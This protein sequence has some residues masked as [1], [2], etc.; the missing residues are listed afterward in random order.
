MQKIFTIRLHWFFLLCFQVLTFHT[1]GAIPQPE[2]VVILILE[3]HSYSQ[4]VGSSA[5]PYINSII[6]DPK[7]ALFT[8]S[9]GLNHPSQPNYIQLFSGSNQG[10]TNNQIPPG[11]PF[12]SPNLGAA[13]LNA[14]KTFAGY[15]E[16]LP[17]VGS[18][19]ET[20][21]P[22]ARKH[23]PWT[24][25]QGSSI[26]G[27]PDTCSRPF[28]D[29]PTD[30]NLLPNVS[31]VIPNLDNQM[32]DGSDPARITRGDTWVHDNLDNYIQWCKTNNSVFI[33]TFDEDDGFS[34]QHILTLFTGQK[35]VHGSYPNPFNHFNVLRTLEEMFN[36]PYAGASATATPIDYCW[37]MCTHSSTINPPG[38][39]YFCSGDS[40]TLSA[41]PSASYL[42]STGETTQTINV[43]SSGIYSVRTDDGLG[44]VATS[45]DVSIT[46][47]GFP[48]AVYVLNESM[49]TVAGAT[50]IA[51]YEANNGFDNDNLT[52]TGSGDIRS[53]L[54]SANYS[55]ASGGANVFLTNTI[56]KNF[57]ISNINTSGLNG[58]ELSFGIFK[59]TTASTASDL[60]VQVSSDG[61]NYTTLS[62]P[63]LPTGTGTAVWHYRTVTG[64]IPSA[65]NLRIQF[66]Q[67]GNT[68]QYRIDDISL[69]YATSS[70]VIS[71][72]G[73]TT[74]CQ[75]GSVH[76]SSTPANSYYW[77]TGET[78][79]SITA[80]TSGN[81]YVIGSISTGCLESSNNIVVESNP[82]VSPTVNISSNIGNTFCA[83]D[84]VIFSAIPSF[85]G[86]APT[87]LWFVNG[88]S[89]GVTTSNYFNNSFLDGDVVTCVMTSN[90]ACASVATVSSN[91]IHMTL[92]MNVAPEITIT[93]NAEDTICSGETVIFTASP[94]F[95]GSNPSYQWKKNGVNVGTNDMFYS[96]NTIVNGDVIT[97]EMTSSASCATPPTATSNGITMVVIPAIVPTLNISATP[98]NNICTGN[99]VI[100]NA[101]PVNG[102]ST[103][104]YQWTKNGFNVGANS[105]HYTDNSLV[106]GD[107]I[108]CI[109]I[110]SAQCPS[111]PF[112]NSNDITITV[113]PAVTPSLSIAP[114]TGTTICAGTSVLFTATPFNEGSAPVYQWKKNGSPVGTNS[115]TFSSSTLVNGDVITCSLTNNDPC[116]TSPTV[117]SN[118]VAMTVNPVAVPVVNILA[119]PGN[120]ICT[121]TNVTFTATAMQAGSSPVYQWKLNG[122][123]IGTNSNTYS[124][125]S[126]SNG[127]VISLVLTGSA[128]CSSPATATSNNITIT[129]NQALTPSVTIAANPGTSIC[130]GTLVT[131]T[132]TPTNGGSSPVYQWKRNTIVV[133]SNSTYS[134]NYSVQGDVITCTMTSNLA[135]ATTPTVV[136]NSLVMTVGTNV[137]P[138][139]SITSNSGNTI[140][141]G[142]N[143]T[144]NA[145]ITNGGTS[146][147]Y[148]WKKNGTNTGV[149]ADFYTN[150]SLVNGD[151]ISCQLTSNVGC[152]TVNPAAS[153]S[154]IMTV[155]S[156]P[157]VS[158]LNPSSGGPGVGV[159]I[160]GS[161]FVGVTSVLFNGLPS[162]FTI[163]SPTQLIAYVPLGTTTGTIQVT[164]ICGSG[165]SS[166]PFTINTTNAV[167]NLKL[168]IE[169]YYAGS[170]QMNNAV[171]A[172]VCDTVMVE[173]HESV[174][175][176]NTIFISR[177]TINRGGNGIFN[178]PS[179]A[180]GN[181]Y[182]IVTYN[183]NTL[184]TWSSAP[185]L[186][187]TNTTYD[188]TIA[189]SKA[190]G[191]NV[192]DLG[193]G[194]FAL[195]SGDVNRDGIINDVDFNEIL[196][197][198]QF[199]QFGYLV[200]DLTGDNI[201]ESADFSLIENNRFVLLVQHP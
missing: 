157:S 47:S 149:N 70:P 49:G 144:F 48:S 133:G 151:V 61:T 124:N 92:I 160:S 94:V 69:K 108:S 136:S 16:N 58:L 20:S 183:H 24:H 175:P 171:D 96:S 111:S 57:I 196:N 27:I 86:P 89:T 141:A 114:N 41:S 12:N 154:I 195:Y 159:T 128:P 150:N 23:C 90:I 99:S 15:A 45:S 146:P 123:T 18:L 158:N 127:D 188:F 46:E 11:A 115:N 191:N 85:G 26:N 60:L 19:I 22:Y 30:F 116:V 169:G 112:I 31:I 189:A 66:L 135:C 56:G 126:L 185:V 165:T 14:S 40:I 186:F 65:T 91:P 109:M 132:A 13:L 81:Y 134:N 182:Y 166:I 75:G 162:S 7:T 197:A 138:T 106:D 137:T 190:F 17:G 200:Y 93:N 37:D 67:T 105:I 63:L 76:L 55:G 82:I 178:F 28:S 147:V 5:A 145:S 179:T 68:S 50:P 174:S 125:S 64:V 181:N 104:Y 1:S 117:V 142:T 33:L 156:A 130:D 80:F 53:T 78:T 6:T 110:S 100:F 172:L 98:G 25:W 131:W 59:S 73:N 164:N 129:V 42:W 95:G 97:C 8:Q 120:S 121:G 201:I 3:N 74:F 79:Q 192:R 101:T 83:G 163:N 84:N 153:N 62:F 32:H 38:P 161:N 44:C 10:V 77:S 35:V 87:Y 119:T 29:F 194:N 88:I 43:S 168:F 170:G 39:I 193:D 155:T 173:L 9:Y 176:Y 177:S 148:Q 184:K 118:S 180:D 71:A 54:P 36:L 152:P 72:S 2:K 103:P 113:H 167:L 198:A 107:I 21:G 139:V 4:I 51:Q 52:M 122:T 140:C 187:S 34:S 143:V 102:G 199:F